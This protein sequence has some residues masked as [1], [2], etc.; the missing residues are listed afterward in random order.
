MPR[1]FCDCKNAAFFATFSGST[2][3][4]KVG[5]EQDRV[6]SFAEGVGRIASKQAKRPVPADFSRAN[7][8]TPFGKRDPNRFWL[9]ASAK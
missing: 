8:A 6:H 2:E 7:R 5:A 4:R 1:V 3:D 9:A